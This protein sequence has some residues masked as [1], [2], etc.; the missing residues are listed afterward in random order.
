MNGFFSKAFFNLSLIEK[1]CQCL[2]I[3]FL[4]FDNVLLKVT[5]SGKFSW[6]ADFSLVC[7][8]VFDQLALLSRNDSSA[9]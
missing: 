8:R 5:T 9:V 3:K 4:I 1:I 2:S 6:V 7:K